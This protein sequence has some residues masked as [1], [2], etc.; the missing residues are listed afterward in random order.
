MIEACTIV[1]AN[2]VAHARVLAESLVAQHPDASFTVLVVDDEAR[3]MKVDEEIDR[4]V[5]WW[6]LADLGLDTAEIHRLAAIYEVTELC[7]SV[8]PL[9]LRVLLRER[10]A[11]VMYL[12]PD[13]RLF[14]SLADIP[15][16]S[17]EH[18]LVL[19]PHTTSAVPD[20]GR[21]IDALSVLAAGVY[22]LGFAGVAPSAEPCLDWWW[23]QTRRHALNDPAHQ[24]FTDQRW[25][26]FIPSLFSAHLLKDPGYNV[27]YWNLH[28]RPLSCSDG[29]VHARGVPLRFFHFSGFDASAPWRLSR[30]QGTN[31]RI[32]LDESPVLAKL[33]E[34][35]AAALNRAGF[36]ASKHRRYG[37]SVTAG[38]IELN[39]R[40]R[41]LYRSALMAAERDQ[42]QEPPDPFDTARPSAFTDWLNTPDDQGLRRWSRYHAAIYHARADLQVHMPDVDGA[43][44]PAFGNWLRTFGGA[45]EG[46]PLP[47]LPRPIAGDALPSEVGSLEPSHR[48]SVRTAVIVGASSGIGE[49]LARELDRAGWRVALLA[50]RLDRLE[51]LRNTLGS[52]TV[53]R[54]VDVARPDAKA[55]LAGLFEE[56]GNVD[57]VIIS[58]GTGHNAAL[59]W[60]LDLETINVNVEGFMAAAHVAMRHFLKHGRGHLVGI[61][62]IAALRGNRAASYAATKAFQSVYLD[63]LR[64]IARHSGHPIDVTEIQPGFVDTAMMKPDRPLP[65]MVN[66]LFVA[67]PEKAAKQILRAIQK[68]KKHAYVTKRY[69][70]IAFIARRLPR[71]G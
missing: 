46:I 55:I 47:L 29:R 10:R 50:R 35:Y 16:L 23:Q 43:D 48:R 12:D 28:E 42:T 13:V 5:R 65:G 71:P 27:A 67:S 49:A 24:M 39:R 62:S 7:T 51:A 40:I 11:P 34:D 32:L 54:R 20:D 22:N 68:R 14:G 37:W 15:R 1:A 30:H 4:R 2:F 33:C 61:S 21:S 58:A 6:R 44:A 3:E 9:F 19:T 17:L 45:E 64:D 18:G 52:E 60:D 36:A 56:L 53:V 57:L 70:L 8:K 69:A 66:R 26:D 38:G 31:P 59:A 41:R 63:G 25:A